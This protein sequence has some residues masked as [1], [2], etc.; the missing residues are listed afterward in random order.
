MRVTQSMLVN[1]FVQNLLGNQ[2]R[3]YEL[4]RQASSG[5][6]LHQPSDDPLAV[7]QVMRFDSEAVDIRRFTDNARDALDWLGATD[8]S[9]QEFHDAVHRAREMVVRGAS[10]SLSDEDRQ[11]V[12]AE[13]DQLIDH[14]I[15]AANATYKGRYIFAGTETLT[16]PFERTAGT[17]TYSGNDLAIERAVGVDARVQVNVPG[18]PL[19]DVLNSLQAAYDDMVANNTAA[20]STVH[21]SALDTAVEALLA[22]RSQVGARA[23]RVEWA[24]ARLGDVAFQVEKLGSELRDADIARVLVDLRAVEVT[25]QATMASASRMFETSLVNFLR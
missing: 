24:S 14:L 9:L 1:H 11:A 10:D 17:I 22:V 25:L 16:R 7:A 20:L 12:A 8:A 4:H 23:N 13:M 21:L 3:M 6:R 19:L 2:R 15:Q 5:V 18:Q